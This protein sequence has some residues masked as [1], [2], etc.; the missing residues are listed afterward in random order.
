MFP[1]G[2]E[3]RGGRGLA[4]VTVGLIV[5]NVV[6]FLFELALGANL[7]S[8]IQ[9]FGAVPH[10]ILTGQDI[11]PP[12]PNPLWIQPLTSMFLHGGWLHI[13]GNMAYLRVF[14]DDIEEALG[15]FLYTLFY[16]GCGVVAS[17]THIVLS[18]PADTVPSIGASGAIAGVMGA[19]L[20]LYPNRRVHV[21]LPSFGFRTG[22]TSALVLLGFWFVLQFFNGIA[23]LSQDT[24]QTGGVAVWAHV[25]G[26]VA[27]ALV[28]LLLRGG[29]RQQPAV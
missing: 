13:I 18:G 9:T 8:F 5:I 24:A 25:G 6:I 11:P 23:A 28:G 12:G 16:L 1:I 10:E 14:G 2:D 27:G 26:F 21:L 4:P 29:H 17:L 20:V 19:Y 15:S 22:Q 3:E 7:D